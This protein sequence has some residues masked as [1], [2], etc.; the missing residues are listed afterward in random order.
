MAA[1]RTG[2]G[3]GETE[4][5][6]LISPLTSH[7]SLLPWGEVPETGRTESVETRQDLESIS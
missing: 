5:S 3:E 1:L 7:L 2:D 4:I 6:I